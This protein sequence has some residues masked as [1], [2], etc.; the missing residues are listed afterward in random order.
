MQSVP[1]FQPMKNIL[2]SLLLI[3]SLHLHAQCKDVYGNK[4]ECPTPEDSLTLYNN[5]IRVIQ[6]YDSNKLYRLTNSVKNPDKVEIFEDLKQA[7]RLFNILRRELKSM[8]PDKFT[9]G[10]PSKDYKDITY[11]Q[12]YDDIDEY[13]F[14]QRELENQI[15]NA[16][17]PMSMYDNR[18]SPIIVNT[19]KCEDSSSVYFNDLV[20]IPLYVPVVVKPYDLLT[21]AELIVRNQTLGLPMPM[22]HKRQAVY[23]DSVPK[24]VIYT[25]NDTIQ[26]PINNFYTLSGPKLP[27][28]LYNSYG[29]A[30]VIGFMIDRKFK[31]LTHEQYADYAVSTFAKSVLEDDIALDKILRI[32][33]GSYYL[34]L[35]Q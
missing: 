21:E 33:F 26:P 14:Y 27:V 8:P 30:C 34:G 31:K 24:E 19:Y 10:K 15:V 23:R 28:Y 12:Y 2:T 22:K 7:R 6:F 9:T 29:S 5:A 4:V 13:R 20:N 1:L 17:A 3:C 11:S 16:N 18:I 35:L 25:R 32:K